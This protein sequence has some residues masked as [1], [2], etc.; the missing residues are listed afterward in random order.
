MRVTMSDEI[1]ILFRV[2]PFVSFAATG[3]LNPDLPEPPC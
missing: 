2:N 1:F 3:D